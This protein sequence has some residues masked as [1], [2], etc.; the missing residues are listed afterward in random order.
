MRAVQLLP[1][2]AG[3]SVWVGAEGGSSQ[4]EVLAWALTD[5]GEVHLVW[6]GGESAAVGAQGWPVTS[7]GEERTDIAAAAAEARANRHRDRE[8]GE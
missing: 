4:C 1:A 7:P 6:W 3:W 8:V 2:E 5:T